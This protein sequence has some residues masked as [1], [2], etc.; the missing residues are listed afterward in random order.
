MRSRIL[1]AIAALVLPLTMLNPPAEATVQRTT[2]AA[3]PADIIG[4]DFPDPDVFEKNGTWYA[5]STNSGRGHVPVASAPS[6][7]GPWTIRGDAMPG[8]PS[9]S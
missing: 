5:Y 3:F 7:N 2:A 9:A 6:A 8:G 4:E 1:A